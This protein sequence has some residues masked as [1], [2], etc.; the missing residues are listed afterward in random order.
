MSWFTDLFK[1]APAKSVLLHPSERRFEVGS[2]ET[3]LERA[4]KEGIAY[5]HDC[6]VGTCGSCRSKLV[7]GR[8]AAITPFSYTLSKDELAAGYILA[9]QAVAKSDL[10]L[11]VEIGAS[12]DIPVQTLSAKLVGLEDLTH[13]IKRVTWE[14][15]PPLRYRAG[16]YVNVRWNGSTIHRSYSL[17][18]PPLS[19]TVTVMN[20]IPFW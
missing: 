15:T 1:K 8:V 19:F 10:V 6:T 18:V 5:P 17:A 9:C 4:L 7:S 14:V 3:V 12:G 20:A 2:G 16:Q 13:D 11:E